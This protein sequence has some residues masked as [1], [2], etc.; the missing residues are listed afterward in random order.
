M[1]LEDVVR[2]EGALR[3]CNDEAGT[4]CAKGGVL[5]ERAAAEDAASVRAGVGDR[6]SLP[7]LAAGGAECK[8]DIPQ[9]L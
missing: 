8:S 4:E 5:Q 3:A 9:L 6:V 1:L 2:L 7:E